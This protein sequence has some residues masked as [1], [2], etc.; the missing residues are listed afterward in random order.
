MD[1]TTMRIR[2]TNEKIRNKVVRR[3]M[4]NI[5]GVPMVVSNCSGGR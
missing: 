2:V 5:A 3:G 1:A 4:W